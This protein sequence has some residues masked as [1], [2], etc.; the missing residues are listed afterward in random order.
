MVLSKSRFI[1][2]LLAAAT[3]LAGTAGFT[4]ASAQLSRPLVQP[5]KTALYQRVIA[6]PGA[7]VAAVPGSDAD[8]RVVPPFSTYYVYERRSHNGGEWLRIG[9]DSSGTLTGWLPVEQ[10]VD[11]KQTLT[12]AFRDPAKQERV[13]LFSDRDALKSILASDDDAAYQQLRADAVSGDM[14]NSPVV[15]MQPDQDVDIRR[16]FYLVPILNHE[17]VLVSGQQARLLQVATVP[18]QDSAAIIDTY[19]TGIVFVIDA[20]VSMKPYIDAT[21]DVMERVYQAIEEAELSNRVSYGLVAFRDNTEAAPGLE[22]VTRNVVRLADGTSGDQFLSSISALDTA[23][24]SSEGFNEDAYAGV[25]EALDAMDWSGFYARYVILITDAGPRNASD[26]FSTT[27]LDAST[28]QR[29]AAARDIAVGV[30]HLKTP[31]GEDNHAYAEDQYRRLS[32]VN[33]IGDFYYPVDTGDVALFESALGA[34]T[35]QVTAQVRAAASG[36]P[37]DRVT[38][39]TATSELDA[40]QEKFS[41]LGYGLRMRYLQD[42]A[43]QSMPSLFNA[44]MVDRDFAA[45]GERSLDVRVLLTRDQLSDLHEVLR[46]VLETAEEGALA[47]ADFL[48][49]LKSLAATI[50]RD[51]EAAQSATRTAGGQS[52]ADLGYMREYLEGLPYTSE[53]MDL[54]LSIWEQWPAQR[55]FEFINQLDGKVAY[56]RALHDNVDLWVSLDGESVDGDSVYPLLL[57]ALP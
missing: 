40:F 17:D 44:W 20:T 15:A 10:T 30:F 55:Q 57:E 37:P 8:P 39:S 3:L 48:D 31:A 33:D 13:L 38:A 53:V 43:G 26:P 35:S 52:L 6:V 56:Y 12:V 7:A 4:T 2:T 34:M 47:P 49:E 9:T 41:R 22:Y 29:R 46:Q 25:S 54:D 5:G 19:R 18:S 1:A 50:S 27:R 45:P 32:N 51:P 21:R 36:L 11:W 42:R 14:Q 28:L 24:V 16:N 23:R